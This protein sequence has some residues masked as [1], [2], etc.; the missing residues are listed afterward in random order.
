MDVSDQPSGPKKG[1][2]KA[3]IAGIIVAIVVIAAVAGAFV[4]LTNGGGTS[5]GTDQNIN[6]GDDQNGNNGPTFQLKNGTFMQFTTIHTSAGMDLTETTRWAVS[7]VTT[8]G[9]DIEISLASGA[10][11]MKYM[12]HGNYS[13]TLGMSG[14]YADM[15]KGVRI[16]TETLATAFGNKQ[17]EHWRLTST[18]DDTTT[19]TDYYIGVKGPVLYK[20]VTTSTG[21]LDPTYNGGSTVVLDDTNIDYIKNGNI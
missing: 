5:N 15:D 8:T 4:L 12:V 11:T 1:L 17:V 19:V 14:G 7:N 20:M 3:F 6:S 13:D 21:V 18:I 2:S 16:G 10:E 9:Y